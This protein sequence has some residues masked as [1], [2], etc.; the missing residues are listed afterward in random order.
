[1]TV[2]E[3]GVGR[4]EVRLVEGRPAFAAPDCVRRGPASGAERDQAVRALGIDPSRVKACQW[5][6]NGPGW[7]A[8]E[9]RDLDDLHAITP[10]SPGRLKIGVVAMSGGDDAAY[11]VRAFFP[12]DGAM[13]G[14]PVTGSLNA[15]VAQWL[16]EDGR[17]TPPYRVRQGRAVGADG[18]AHVSAT[19][20]GRLWVGGDV[21]PVI[22][23]RVVLTAD[24]D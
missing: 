15:S 2:Q 11:H 20:D 19:D 12:V 3:C 13:R 1:M 24:A 22:R 17:V 4:V 5:V 16:V 21:R 8:V 9:V 6:D 23:G 10:V 14:D 7:I 18:V